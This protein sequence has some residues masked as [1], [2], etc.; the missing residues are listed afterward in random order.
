[1]HYF[2]E[3]LVFQSWG[4]RTF[5]FVFFCLKPVFYRFSLGAR[6]L[7]RLL[8]L[9]FFGVFLDLLL[10]VKE[11]KCFSFVK[12]NFGNRSSDY[13]FN[14]RILIKYIDMH[15]TSFHS[16]V[17]CRVIDWLVHIK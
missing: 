5:F 10:I 9:L 15:V 7:L 2:L 16:A 8:V 4:P 13:P 12:S 14:K 17:F 3:S 6:V 1:M 11:V